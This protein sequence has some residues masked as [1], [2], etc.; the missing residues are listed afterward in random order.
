MQH[1]EKALCAACRA[2]DCH[3]D[4]S[5]TRSGPHGIGYPA[6]FLPLDGH[7]HRCWPQNHAAFDAPNTGWEGYAFESS[8]P[9]ERTASDLN[10]LY[11]PREGDLSQIP[12]ELESSVVIAIRRASGTRA[13]FDHLHTRWNVH[14]CD[15]AAVEPA[16]F[17]A[18]QP[19]W[20]HDAQT[21]ASVINV[22]P[23]LAELRLLL[24]GERKKTFAA[25]KCAP[26][27]AL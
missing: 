23:Y 24:E 2:T 4:T 27:D 22:F 15:S 25:L 12:A 3:T 16:L 7:M 10:Q 13:P 6:K 21:I 11:R 18:R 9:A 5:E 14:L 20:E 26:S 17:D 8:A 1:I 19:L